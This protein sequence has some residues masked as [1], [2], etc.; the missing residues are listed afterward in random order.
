MDMKNDIEIFNSLVNLISK[1]NN[2]ILQ[3][4]KRFRNYVEK[5]EYFE[6]LNDLKEKIKIIKKELEEFKSY[7]SEDIIKKLNN[8]YDIESKVDVLESEIKNV[9]NYDALLEVKSELN[10]IKSTVDKLI[11]DDKSIKDISEKL[12][13]LRKQVEEILN[14][15][16]KME[17]T[18]TKK[19]EF[20]PIEKN[21]KELN[22]IINTLS[23]KFVQVFEQYDSILYEFNEI[24]NKKL[25]DLNNRINSI[26]S[27]LNKKLEE[28][29]AKLSEL[30]YLSKIS[31][32]DIKKLK[33]I[34][35]YKNLYEKYLSFENKL[36]LIYKIIDD[37][38]ISAV[39]MRDKIENILDSS[40]VKDLVQNYETLI[41][42]INRLKY[43]IEDIKNENRDLKDM[44]Y[45]ITEEI[46]KLEEKIKKIEN[47]LN[48]MNYDYINENI[49]KIFYLEEEIKNIKR[50]LSKYI[51]EGSSDKLSEI[52][53]T[54]KLLLEQQNYI[55]K[56]LEKFNK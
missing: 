13:L 39:K 50:L 9:V 49:E 6:A 23:S 30:S 52:E 48:V 36:S 22:N 8:L 11:L 28:L 3:L 32:E 17:N 15:V 26:E 25:E 10:E 21:I 4:E 27:E 1:A 16:E 24:K 47:I 56:N 33:Y 19:E 55:L 5:D 43:E 40:K 53:N 42:N 29:N 41:N 45:S 44:I 38:Q 51:T 34:D 20:K 31:E 54:I 35:K 12:T 7:L 14:R 46:Q 18:Y 37:L 2:K